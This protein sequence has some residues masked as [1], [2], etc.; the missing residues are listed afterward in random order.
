MCALTIVPSG[1]LAR[2]FPHGVVGAML[3]HPGDPSLLLPEERDYIE[4]AVPKRILEFAAGRQCARAA[5]AQF[6]IVDA[7]LPV[8][9]DRTPRWPQGMVGSLTH[10]EGLCAAVVAER[11]RVEALGIDAEVTERVTPQFW[12][13]ICSSGER[14]WLEGLT[15]P[16]QSQ[17]AALIFSAKEAAYK[18]MYPLCGEWLDFR[19]LAIEPQ[20]YDPEAGHFAIRPLRRLRLDEEVVSQLQGRF[21]LTHRI[22]LS[23]VALTRS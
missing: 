14:A 19:D 12:T 18:C 17:A 5:L 1:L 15:G 21:L 20:G 8:N 23:G 4:R 9:Q 13:Q 22:V 7:P 6:G 2:L 16:H 11:S 10:T 3:E